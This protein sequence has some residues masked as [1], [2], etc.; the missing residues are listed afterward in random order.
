MNAAFMSSVKRTFF[1]ATA[2]AMPASPSQG[3]TTILIC[4]QG[5]IPMPQAWSGT[6]RAEIGLANAMTMA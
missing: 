2:R 6:V 4:V 1:G 5:G 3:L